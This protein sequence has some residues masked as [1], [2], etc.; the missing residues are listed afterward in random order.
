MRARAVRPSNRPPDAVFRAVPSKSDTHRALVAAALARGESAVEFP[1][2]ADDT[3]R[4]REALAALGARFAA[5]PTG[6]RVEGTAGRIAGGASLELGE[7][8]TTCRLLAAIAAL[9]EAPSTL[10]GAPRLRER[11]MRPLLDALASLGARVDADART[12]GLPVRIGGPLRG[13]EVRVPGHPTSQF[14]SA[15]LL[16]GARITGGIEV[17][18]VPPRVS[19]PYLRMTRRTLERFGVPLL[20]LDEGRFRVPATDYPGIPYRVEGDHSSASY[21]LAAAIA[22]RGRVRV[23]GL[24]PASL[25]ADAAF[26]PLLAAA[27]ARVESGNE[28]IAVESTGTLAAFDV[29]LTDSPDLAPTVAVASLFADGRCRLRGLGHLRVKE[30]DRLAALAE[31][32][33]AL[34]AAVVVEGDALIVTPP[35]RLVAATVRTRS[36]HRLAM[37]FAVAGLRGPGVVVDDA[38]CVA[39]SNPGFWDD[40][41]ALEGDGIRTGS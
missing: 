13:G 38:S 39:K 4:T 41:A 21:L 15:L 5:F 26:G 27:G 8:G 6:W 3:A 30:S 31:N 16:V 2:R 25:Q 23:E 37:A 11:P 1:L 40:F 12:G 14:G 20:E 10:D 33:T 18:I 24:D 7:S 29:D 22:T 19:L 9:G 34:G 28:G 35:A 17:E 36:D 32:L